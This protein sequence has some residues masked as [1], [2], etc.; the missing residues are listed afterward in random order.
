[1]ARR[2]SSTESVVARHLFARMGQGK[3]MPVPK[4]DEI[5]T[6]GAKRAAIRIVVRNIEQI[7]VDVGSELLNRASQTENKKQAAGV[8]NSINQSTGRC[9]EL[10]AAYGK[11]ELRRVKIT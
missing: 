9:I 7:D 8:H 10:P 3:A 6:G 1:M 4:S 2:I 11:I 5:A